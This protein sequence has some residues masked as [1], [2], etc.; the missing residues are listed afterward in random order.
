MKPAKQLS[1]FVNRNFLR[2]KDPKLLHRKM[3]VGISFDSPNTTFQ[4]TLRHLWALKFA[5]K[6]YF[7][8]L[9]SYKEDNDGHW[10]WLAWNMASGG[11]AGAKSSLL[12]Y[13]LGYARTWLA[14]DTKS[15]NKG[16]EPKYDGLID[17]YKRIL[18]TDGIAGLYRG[19]LF[20]LNITGLRG[21]SANRQ[22]NVSDD[23]FI[24]TRGL[25]FTECRW[26]MTKS[27]LIENSLTSIDP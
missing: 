24:N 3:D 20:L 19:Y 4:L 12:L 6:D 1:M 11:A 10:K 22:S 18:R 16:G 27:S 23:E 8:S 2:A 5:F 15:A 17:V 26:P 13:S 14:N 21:S 9:L 25:V 7:K